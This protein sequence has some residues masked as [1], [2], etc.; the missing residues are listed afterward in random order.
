MLLRSSSTPILNSRIPN[1]NPTP[2]PKDSPHE[3]EI[4]H[5]IPRTRSL[6][7]SA[8]SNSLSPVDAS[9]CRMT[10]A[11]SETDLSAWSKTAS[12]GS[13]LF[14]FT[15]SDENESVSAEGGGSGGG[16]GGGRDNGDGGGSGFSDSNNGNDST[17]LYYRTMI[18]ANPGNSLFLGNYARYLKEVQGDYVKAEEY[19]GRAI[20]AN[21]NDGKVLS[22]YADLIWESHKDASRAETYF[23]QAVKAAPDDC[24]VLASYAHFL[25]DAEEEDLEE[26]EDSYE[27][28]GGFVHGVG[29][30][31]SPLTASTGNPPPTLAIQPLEAFEMLIT[32]GNLAKEGARQLEFFEFWIDLGLG[33]RKLFG[34]CGKEMLLLL[35]QFLASIQLMVK[36]H[37]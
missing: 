15:E 8:S 1:P 17:D 9:P 14:S 10:R 28:S 3:H 34:I 4:F 20:L 29:P 35:M 7:L 25:W 37:F 32:N 18:E 2:N 19:C 12:F 11:L 27:K 5:R 6:M 33:K 21:P 31:P 16:G 30:P 23:D 22:M 24:Y 26:G 13:A 36:V